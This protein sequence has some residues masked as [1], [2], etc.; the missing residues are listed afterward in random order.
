MRYLKE[1]GKVNIPE[2][3]EEEFKRALLTFK[4]QR[5][6][7]PIREKMV[8]LNDIGENEYGKEIAKYSETRFLGK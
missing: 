8:M 4:F 1:E 5:V 7:C 2:N 3:Y 6:Y